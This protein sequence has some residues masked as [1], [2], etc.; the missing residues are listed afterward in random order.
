MLAAMW[1]KSS[2]CS[3]DSEGLRAEGQEAAWTIGNRTTQGEPSPPGSVG[4]MDV[5]ASKAP[6]LYTTP[7]SLPPRGSL[8]FVGKASFP[9]DS[10]PPRT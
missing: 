5:K 8:P 6:A 4:G 10:G 2:S 9:R 7:S 3:P 1:K